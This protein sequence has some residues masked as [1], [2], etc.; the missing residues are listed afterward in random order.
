MPQIIITLN[1]IQVHAP[2]VTRAILRHSGLDLAGSKLL[3]DSLFKDKQ[4]KI[5]VKSFDHAKLLINDL[6][7]QGVKSVM[8]SD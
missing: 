6:R 7:V 1:S 5:S 4:A 3:S 2:L 8:V